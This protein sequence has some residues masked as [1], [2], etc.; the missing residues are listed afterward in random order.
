MVEFTAQGSDDDGAD[1]EEAFTHESPSAAALSKLLANKLAPS[2]HQ[3]PVS[4]TTIRKYKF[5]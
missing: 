1:E 5:F 3:S 4:K 2:H